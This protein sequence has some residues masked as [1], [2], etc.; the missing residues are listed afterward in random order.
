MLLRGEGTQTV[1]RRPAPGNRGALGAAASALP[2]WCILREMVT[3]NQVP[4]SRLLTNLV[5][6]ARPTRVIA[7]DSRYLVPMKRVKVDETS[8]AY[9]LDFSEAQRPP[10]S[11]SADVCSL[12]VRDANV[13]FVFGQRQL[14]GEELDSAL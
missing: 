12:S 7:Q 11:Y 3:R 8:V 6:T 1:H 10:R 4:P 2:P 5:Q 14:V 13:H 9:V